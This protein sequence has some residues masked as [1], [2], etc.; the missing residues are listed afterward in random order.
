MLKEWR[1]KSA[2]GNYVRVRW[3]PK[4][5]EVDTGAGWEVGSNPIGYAME[6]CGRGVGECACPLSHHFKPDPDW[7]KEKDRR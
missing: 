1:H 6:Y 5:L 7:W 4:G 2:H 3:T